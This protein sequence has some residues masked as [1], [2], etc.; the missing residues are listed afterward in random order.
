MTASTVTLIISAEV[1]G[2]RVELGTAEIPISEKLDESIYQGMQGMGQALYGAILQ[3]IDDGLRETAPEG[4]QNMGR[5][6]RTVMTCVGSVTYKRRVYKDKQGK[7]RKPI[8]EVLGIVPY[9]RYSLGVQQ[10]GSYLASE[11]PYREAAD[12]LSWLIRNH[13]SHSSIGRMIRFVGGSYQAEEQDRIERVF[14]RGEELEPGRI[15][16][17]VLYGESDGVFIPLQ[18]ET[19]KKVEVRVG[20]LYTGKKAIGVGRRA[21]ENKVVVTKIVENSQEWKET[22]F[23]TAY[24]HYDL[25]KTSQLIVG[26]DGN[27][28]VKQ[29]FDLLELPTVFVLDRYHLYRNA[30]R[31]FGFTLKTETW[32]RKICEGDL[33]GV[34]SDMLAVAAKSPPRKAKDMK[35]F[36]Q[37]LINNKDGLLDTDCRSHLQTG[38]GNL[39]GIEGNVDKLVVRRLKGRGRSWRLDGVKAM[40]EVCRH[41]EEL[42]QGAFKTFIKSSDCCQP[43]KGRQKKI[44][45]GEWLQADVPAIHLCHSGRPWAKVL[46]EIIHP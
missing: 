20:V 29:S 23:R 11:L 24:E 34:L 6:Q 33:E 44:D 13:V 42:R 2:Q 38:L 43:K 7:R 30:R 31:A 45:Y 14:E 26:G 40:L 10:Q 5:E 32:I 12:I 21:L 25:S 9:G 41:K 18:R 8:D 35:A 46:K 27:S 19:K 37:Y 16:A 3:G 15:Q 22:V 39:G 1:S 28:W 36:I 4:W 17:K